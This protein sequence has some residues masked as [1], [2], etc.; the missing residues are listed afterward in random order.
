MTDKIPHSVEIAQALVRC[1]SVTPQE[2]GA[3]TYLEGVL[4][5]AGSTPTVLFSPVMA[6]MTLTIFTPALAQAHRIFAMVVTRM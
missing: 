5:D 4:K 6:L 2:G 3:L 1:P